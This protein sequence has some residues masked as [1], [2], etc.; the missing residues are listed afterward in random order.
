MMS[1]YYENYYTI[2]EAIEILGLD[3]AVIKSALNQLEWRERL[4]ESGFG[5]LAYKIIKVD[6]YKNGSLEDSY[7][8]LRRYVNEYKQNGTFL[9]KPKKEF[10]EKNPQIVIDRTLYEC[11]RE[12]AEKLSKLANKKITVRELAEVAIL[13]Y[14]E[15]IGEQ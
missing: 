3:K 13:G 5:E 15:Q 14:I 1:S 11:L 12:R 7:K 10:A 2:D 9:R 6:K 8:I 4:K